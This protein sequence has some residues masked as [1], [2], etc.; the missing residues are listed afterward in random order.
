MKRRKDVWSDYNQKNKSAGRCVPP[1]DDAVLDYCL[2][3]IVGSCLAGRSGGKRKTRRD[4]PWWNQLNTRET[5]SGGI[6]TIH[7]LRR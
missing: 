2:G 5:V 6:R 4:N 1:C 3:T 7:A